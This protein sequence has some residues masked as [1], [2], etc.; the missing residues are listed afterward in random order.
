MYKKNS[1]EREQHNN[2]ILETQIKQNHQQQQQKRNSKTIFPISPDTAHYAVPL[3]KNQLQKKSKKPS[4]IIITLFF[5][6]STP[7]PLSLDSQQPWY[8]FQAF[9]NCSRTFF[10]RTRKVPRF[11]CTRNK[12]L[13]QNKR[14]L[15]HESVVQSRRVS[16]KRKGRGAARRILLSPLHTM[17]V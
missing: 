3:Q 9:L 1:L 14:S 6:T 8:M 10:F 5:H 13:T 4:S 17:P 7:N 16:G 12:A 15:T 2:R 11:H